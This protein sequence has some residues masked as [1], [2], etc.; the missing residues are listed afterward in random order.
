MTGHRSGQKRG[1]T[2]L[3]LI[4]IGVAAVAITVVLVVMGARMLGTMEE[5]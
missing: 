4:G 5:Q 1:R 3:I 2:M